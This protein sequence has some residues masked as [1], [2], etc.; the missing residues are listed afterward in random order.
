MNSLH[1]RGRKERERGDKFHYYLSNWLF[2]TEFCKLLKAPWISI[3]FDP[4]PMCYTQLFLSHLT[5]KL[6]HLSRIAL[7]ILI[8]IAWR[9]VNQKCFIHILFDLGL[10]QFFSFKFE[11]YDFDTWL[12]V[13]LS[14]MSKIC[15]EIALN[16]HC[17]VLCC[18]SEKSSKGLFNTHPHI[19]PFL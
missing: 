4:F 13:F 18:K 19:L 14:I 2:M 16:F 9:C 1:D 17:L 3:L 11:I 8:F 10:F 5:H 6:W 15:V 12:L 7:K